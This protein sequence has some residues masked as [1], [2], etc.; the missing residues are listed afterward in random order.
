M[1]NIISEQNQRPELKSYLS[2]PKLE[3][4]IKTEEKWSTILF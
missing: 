3:T 1:I 2:V 4:L